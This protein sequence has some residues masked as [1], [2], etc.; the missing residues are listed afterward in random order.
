MQ[1]ECIDNFSA[2]CVNFAAAVLVWVRPSEIPRPLLAATLTFPS[3]SAWDGSPNPRSSA[4]TFGLEGDS[5]P[6][7]L[8]APLIETRRTRMGVRVDGALSAF[9]R[10]LRKQRVVEGDG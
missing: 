1:V 7:K 9:W 10:K 6:E 3:V 2:P 4:R 5:G 8:V